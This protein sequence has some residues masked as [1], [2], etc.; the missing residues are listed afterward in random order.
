MCV[1]FSGEENY[2][3]TTNYVAP[4]PL[5]PQNLMGLI[6]PSQQLLAYLEYNSKNRPELKTTNNYKVL[7]AGDDFTLFYWLPSTIF[8]EKGKTKYSINYRERHKNCLPEGVVVDDPLRK[9]YYIFPA[10]TTAS[11]IKES[12]VVGYYDKSKFPADLDGPL[13]GVGQAWHRGYNESKKPCNARLS[14]INVHIPCDGKIYEVDHFEF[15]CFFDQS[16]E[17]SHYLY[18]AYNWR[19]YASDYFPPYA[20]V[21]GQGPNREKIYVGRTRYGGDDTPGYIMKSG[22][23]KK[24]HVGHKGVELVKYNCGDALNLQNARECTTWVKCSDGNVPPHALVGNTSPDH[25]LY[26]GRTVTCAKIVDTVTWEKE[27]ITLPKEMDDAQLVGKVDPRHGCLC[28]PWD[29]KEII[30]RSYEVLCLK[31]TPK[32][33]ERL[34]YNTVFTFLMKN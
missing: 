33:L 20:L 28:I 16:A 14:H 26:I 19:Y 1:I 34:C 12:K 24:H 5:R 30:Y 29:G 15:L 9:E 22:M 27:P 10:R 11:V 3:G 6:I 31:P 13:V 7:V 23:H 25:K 2:I 32:S 17:I 8:T 4:E 18:P 21:G